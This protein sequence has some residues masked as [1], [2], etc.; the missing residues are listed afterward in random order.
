MNKLYISIM[1]TIVILIA[2]L[3]LNKKSGYKRIFTDLGVAIVSGMI[4]F[5]IS[6]PLNFDKKADTLDH[7]EPIQTMS[8]ID[9]V[10]ASDLDVSQD[11]E[12]TLNEQEYM[13][14]YLTAMTKAINNNDFS[15]VE[16]YLKIDGSA[17][18]EQKDYITNYCQK[19]EITEKVKEVEI[20]N[21]NIINKHTV[22]VST[23]ETY[24][25]TSPTKGNRVESFNTQ[26][27]IEEINGIWKISEIV[28]N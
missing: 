12:I 20:L 13:E 10:K 19:N 27:T 8:A 4:V 25:I 11:D 21:D 23:Y 24:D 18:A 9:T 16:K 28:N 22:E 2:M 3:L 14:E 26:Y 1:A 7:T 6:E 17:Y 5:F 15:K